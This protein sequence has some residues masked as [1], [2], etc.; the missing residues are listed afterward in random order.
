MAAEN[1]CKLLEKQL[2]YM[3]KMVQSA[4]QD[5][6][7]TIHQSALLRQENHDADEAEIRL[8]LRKIQELERDHLKLTATQTMAENK[9]RELE[10]KLLEERHHR[11][12]MQ[13]KAANVSDPFCHYI[14]V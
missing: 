5:K 3:R 6:A 8:E 10:E 14:V 2:D 1:R 7:E 12:V 11:K 13:E 4:E 9:I